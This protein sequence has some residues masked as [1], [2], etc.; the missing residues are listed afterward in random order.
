MRRNA[1]LIVSIASGGLILVFAALIVFT[2][3]GATIIQNAADRTLSADTLS[4]RYEHVE[5]E[6]WKEAS[7]VR[8]HGLDPLGSDWNSN[9]QEERVAAESIVSSLNAIESTGSAEDRALA[10]DVLADHDRY[11]DMLHVLFAQIDASLPEAAQTFAKSTRLFDK[12]Q[13]RIDRRASEQHDG[14]VASLSKLEQTQRYVVRMISLGATLAGVLLGAAAFL[15]VRYRR[16]IDASRKNELDRLTAASL[17]DT[18]TGLGNHRAY[19]DELARDLALLKRHGGVVTLALI[20]IDEF[21][22]VNDTKG[23]IFGDHILT[24]LAKSI[25]GLRPSDRGFRLGGDE[26]AIILPHADSG[27]ALV[28][29]ERL[30]Q[31]AAASLDGTTISIGISST[32]GDDLDAV[33][34]RAQA[35]I[36]LY[37]AKH[38]GRNGVV[39]Y[40]VA[41]TRPSTSP[42]QAVLR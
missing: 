27:Q 6:L 17:T 38:H 16:V 3:L 28:A 19:Q 21:K 9:I 40:S 30:R 34:L 15:I 24:T 12:M 11:T 20:D 8:V 35:D 37:D 10:R 5:R 26:F 29:M 42:A 33:T 23:H 18:L 2:A 22:S 32:T 1:R 4:H 41:R 14:A 25:G 7:L 36:A 31:E 13:A 39:A